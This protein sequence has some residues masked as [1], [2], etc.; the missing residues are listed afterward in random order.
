MA[1]MDRQALATDNKKP[2]PADFVEHC[3]KG[4]RELKAIYKCGDKTLA[5]WRRVANLPSNQGRHASTAARVRWAELRTPPEDFKQLAMQK[6]NRVLAEYYGVS[7]NRITQWRKDTGTSQNFHQF[8]KPPLPK[9]GVPSIPPGEASEAC[10]FLRPTHR[11]VYDRGIVDG[12]AFKGQFVV[13][14][15][16]LS[17]QELINYARSRGFKTAAEELAAFNKYD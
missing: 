1:G 17:E 14:N 15:N 7:E 9:P 2:V 4:N 10:Q 13:G 8:V 3:H 11:P 6:T 12:K 5:R 16:V